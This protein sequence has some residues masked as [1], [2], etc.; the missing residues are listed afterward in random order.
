MRKPHVLTLLLA[1]LMTFGAAHVASADVRSDARTHYLAGQNAYSSGDYR[2]AIR[3]F[4]AAQQLM[5]ADLN[6]YNLAL[7]YDKLGDA[8]SA[9]QYYREY[10]NKVPNTDKR[11]EIE[12]SISRLDAASQA[13]A[14]KRAEEQRRADDAR[15]IEQSRQPD[16]YA[17]APAPAPSGYPPPAAYPPPAPAPSAYPG[18]TPP[19]AGAP[20]D[21]SLSSVQQIDINQIRNQRGVTTGPAVAANDPNA[22]GG[23]MNPNAPPAGPNGPNGALPNAVPGGPAVEVEVPVYKKWW[24]WAVVGVSLYVVYEIATENSDNNSAT[25]RER[26][27]TRIKTNEPSSGP[28]GLTLLRW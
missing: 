10:L 15:R 11:G 22:T 3:E 8:D 4:G 26:D 13:A 20:T 24:F 28:Q 2:A 23:P 6:S 18:S 14:A 17:P 21:P 9:I 27:Y 7:C 25:A 5:P 19:P 12:A 1:V 16:P